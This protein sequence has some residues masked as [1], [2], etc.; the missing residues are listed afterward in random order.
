MD[1]KVSRIALKSEI[2]V[3]FATCTSQPLDEIRDCFRRC[4]KCQTS[5]IQTP[6]AWIS[7]E[8]SDLGKT[9]IPLCHERS[10]IAFL[11]SCLLELIMTVFRKKFTPDVHS[12][13]AIKKLCF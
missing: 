13:I 12:V 11:W 9:L 6:D 2:K 7:L 4:S 8:M 3:Y 1:Q 10:E 5:K